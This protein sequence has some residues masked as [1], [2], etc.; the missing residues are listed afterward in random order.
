MKYY[1]SERLVCHDPCTTGWRYKFLTS[2]STHYNQVHHFHI[3]SFH[4]PSLLL[5]MTTMNFYFSP[6]QIK[7]SFTFTVPYPY[8][9]FW[10]PKL[11]M[12]LIKTHTRYALSDMPRWDALNFQLRGH[13]HDLTQMHLNLAVHLHTGEHVKGLCK[14]LYFLCVCV[15]LCVCACVSHN[16]VCGVAIKGCD[17]FNFKTKLTYQ[18]WPPKSLTVLKCD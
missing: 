2:Y 1:D 3:A 18:V 14:S 11:V 7:L 15:C 16:K 9:I 13:P 4:Q 17:P 5:T 6:W 8:C 10:V 12:V